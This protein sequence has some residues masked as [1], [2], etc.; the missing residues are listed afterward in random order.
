MICV[1]ASLVLAFL[2]RDEEYT[3]EV[4]S[5][6]LAWRESQET[7]IAP[8]LFPFEVVSGL[9]LAVFS[10]RISAAEGDEVYTRFQRMP[11]EL[12]RPHTLFDRTWDIGKRMRPPRLYDA[13]YLA[14]AELE[15]CDVWTAD[16]RFVNLVAGR[17]PRLKW[18]GE[19]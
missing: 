6:F 13:S 7:L 2:L 15:D 9:R 10:S 19:A 17:S 1:D 5:L 16:R 18:A 12:R 3:E 14:L 11:I 8:D 4:T